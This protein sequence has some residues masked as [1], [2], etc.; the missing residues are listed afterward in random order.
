MS[1]DGGPT[2]S[3]AILAQVRGVASGAALAPLD[4]LNDLVSLSEVSR[5]A[6]SVALDFGCDIHDGRLMRLWMSTQSGETT[7]GGEGAKG[8]WDTDT[9][10]GA[11]VVLT[12]TRPGCR[13]SARLTNE[14]LVASFKRVRAD[15]EAGRGLSIA[16]FPLSQVGLPN[17]WLQP[18]G[19]NV[20]VKWRNAGGSSTMR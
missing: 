9:S 20:A 17:L 19:S 12:C 7:F 13:N 1:R 10:G 8:A 4:S 2:L 3:E 16:W 15:F 18:S 5:P 11:A 6:G 14:W